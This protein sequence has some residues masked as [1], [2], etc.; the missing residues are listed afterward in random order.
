MLS[1]NDIAVV[2]T[3]LE[4]NEKKGIGNL[5]LQ[6][7]LYFA[8]AR[9]A[10]ANNGDKLLDEDFQKWPYGP[11]LESAYR[12]LSRYGNKT[13]TKCIKT[14]DGEALV[15]EKSSPE[16]QCIQEVSRNLEDY[17]GF[18][19][20]D[21]THAKGSPWYEAEKRGTIEF[22]KIV[23]YFSDNPELVDMLNG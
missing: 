9:W 21:I 20:S 8:T 16:Y 14:D 11:V 17:P 18:E 2:N 10:I 19:L 6:K 1:V 7:L 4:C 12:A 22:N 3:V 13:I 23:S 5:K 15:Y